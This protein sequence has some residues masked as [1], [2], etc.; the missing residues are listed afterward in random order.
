MVFDTITKKSMSLILDMKK[1]ST[2]SFGKSTSTFKYS[3]HNFC[4]PQYRELMDEDRD[5][6]FCFFFRFF[7][8]RH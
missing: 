7:L 2:I 8:H 3:I 5:D 6:I 1:K 4:N